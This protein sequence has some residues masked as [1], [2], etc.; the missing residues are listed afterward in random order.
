MGFSD[1]LGCLAGKAQ[2]PPQ[3][4]WQPFSNAEDENTDDDYR[5]G[6]WAAIINRAK[7]MDVNVQFTTDG[8]KM[9]FGKSRGLFKDY[10]G[11]VKLASEFLNSLGS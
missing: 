1:L 2:M 9:S 10:K 8:I 7:K 6:D 3:T 11:G 5:S 4:G